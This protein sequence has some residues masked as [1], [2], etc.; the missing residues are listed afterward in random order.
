[1]ATMLNAP[2]IAEDEQRLVLR[3]ISWSQNLTTS[4]ALPDW[5]C[6]RMILV[7][8]RLTFVSPSRRHDGYA[9]RLSDVN[10]GGKVQRRAG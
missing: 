7:D 9:E 6:L 1:M 8:G 2:T 3:G 4:D 5:P 10:G